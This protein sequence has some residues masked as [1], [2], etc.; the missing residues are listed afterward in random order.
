MK[1]ILN[2]DNGI[3]TLLSNVDDGTN[4][5]YI[6]DELVPS[7]EWTGTGYYAFTSGGLTF[8]I[9]KIRDDSGNIMLQLIEQSGGTSYRM[10]KA[11]SAGDKYYSIEDPAEIDLADG[12]YMP[13]Y[14]TSAGRKKKTLWS[15]IVDKIKSSFVQKSGDTMSGALT[16]STIQGIKYTGTK[17]TYPMIKFIDNTGDEYGNGI[18][19]GGGGLTIVGGGESADT[20]ASGKSG[21]E[22]SLY[23]TNDGN[24]IVVTNLQNGTSYGKTF[25]FGNDGIF[26]SPSTI[27]QNNVPVVTSYDHPTNARYGGTGSTTKIKIKINS[28]ASWMLCFTVVLYQGYRATK[29][30]ISGYNYGANHWYQPEAVIIADSDNSQLIPVY[31]G[32]DATNQLWVGFDGGSYTGVAII[33]VCNGYTQISNYDNLFTISNAS[34]LTTEQTVINAYFYA[35]ECTNAQNANYASSAG[36]ANNSSKLGGYSA[37]TSATGNTIAM[38]QANGYLYATYF[39]QSSGAE[40]PTSSSYVIY[41]NSDGFF[42]KSSI[43]NMKSLIDTNTWRGIQN[44]LTSTSTTDSLSANQG[45]LLANGSA[46]DSTK[47]PLAGG[48]CTGKVYSIDT[49]GTSEVLLGITRVTAGSSGT[50]ING[51]SYSGAGR[52]RIFGGTNAAYHSDI[53]PNSSLNGNRT[54]TLP[55]TTGTLSY[56]SSSRRVKTNIRAMTDEEAQKLLGIDI[57]KFDYKEFWNNG[58]KNQSGLIAEDVIKI[59]PEAVHIR[60]EYDANLPVDEEHNFPP[61]VEYT[62]FVPYLIKMVQIQQEQINELKSEIKALKEG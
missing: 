57:I 45:R 15:N 27:K 31:F 44:N 20:F 4:T 30:M 32:Y 60:K 52:V 39:N 48:T 17:A 59:I 55:A 33:D 10:I 42:R 51:K 47:L 29:V 26:N 9:Q 53:L 2:I 61:E 56:A 35:Y 34:S 40:T 3:P 50:T 43:A 38:R 6:N 24:V 11:I 19:I 8:T 41:C 13:F 21:G 25:T 14:D 23:L 58:E 28:T 36:T 1:N 5:L 37:S 22:E 46:R 18:L 54:V 12:D 7:S 62:K 49:I 16:F